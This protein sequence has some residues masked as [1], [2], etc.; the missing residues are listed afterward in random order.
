VLYML[1]YS[2]PHARCVNFILMYL[3]IVMLYTNTPICVNCMMYL[4]SPVCT[5]LY[6]YF[7][8]NYYI[9]CKMFQSTQITLKVE[10]DITKVFPTQ[11]KFYSIYNIYMK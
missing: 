10:T 5:E 8:I 3:F 1:N 7:I 9:T 11:L 4:F 2:R 6:I